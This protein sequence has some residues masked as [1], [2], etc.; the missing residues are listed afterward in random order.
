MMIAAFE[1]P[2]QHE[3]ITKRMK[4]PT[5]LP[6]QSELHLSSHEDPGTPSQPKMLANE[7][8]NKGSGC[9]TCSV[10]Q[11]QATLPA[12]KAAICDFRSYVIF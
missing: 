4:I 12:S 9:N 11:A 5:F 7:G 8:D 10:M 1:W 2:K 3:I 6:N